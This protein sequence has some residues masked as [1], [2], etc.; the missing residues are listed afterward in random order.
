MATVAV[1]LRV[2]VRTAAAAREV[3]RLPRETKSTARTMNLRAAWTSQTA[4]GVKVRALHQK[5]ANLE[6]T[7]VRLWQVQTGLPLLLLLQQ[8]VHLPLRN[9]ARRR[10]S[11]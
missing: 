1:K 2:T 7:I 9:H 4:M 8:R 3:V 5:Q 10:S 6:R 11:S